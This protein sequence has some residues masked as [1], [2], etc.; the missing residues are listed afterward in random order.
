[1]AICHKPSNPMTSHSTLVLDKLRPLVDDAIEKLRSASFREDPIGGRK[2]S[3]ATS[4]MSSAYKR[5]GKILEMALLERLKECARLKVWREDDFK[6]SQ[7]SL[8]QLHIHD[9]IEK[10]MRIQL[11]Y[12][13]RER[14]IPID[15]VVYDRETTMLTSYNVKRGNGS[16]DGGK[17]RIIQGDLL[18]TH[19]LL[20]DYGRRM[21]ISVSTA[22]SRIVFYYG[23]LSIPKPLAIAGLELDDHFSFPVVDAIEQVNA[24]FRSRLHELV[25]EE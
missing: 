15:I 9:R 5:H 7:E 19:M 23:L 10:C 3:R 20:A 6:L 13:D 1:M 24:Y 11:D 21:G 18:R 2:Y 4:I 8:N 14:T 16:Y 22:R 17:R 12:G 25:E